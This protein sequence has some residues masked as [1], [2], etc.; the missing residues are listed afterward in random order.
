MQGPSRTS[1][2]SSIQGGTALPL[3]LSTLLAM[4][5]LVRGS[6]HPELNYDVIP[7]VA[8]AKHL[9]G[10]GGKA[11]AFREVAAK[12]GTERFQLY[13]AE[14]YRQRMYR[15]DEY[16]YRNESLYTI[17][18]FYILTCAAVGAVIHDDVAAT[19]LISAVSS[20]VAVLVSLLLAREVG[21]KGTWQL[22]APF[23]WVV[24][25]GL[26][27]AGLSTPDG[28]ETL[29]TLLFV[30]LLWHNAGSIVSY[31][32]L[33]MLAILMVATRTDAVVLV[34]FIL[35]VKWLYD[36]RARN[37]VLLLCAGSWLTYLF[38]QH[39]S[40]NFGYIAV[41]N[42]ALIE[43]GQHD[44]FPNLVPHPARFA[45]AFIH[46][47]LQVLGENPEF[48]RFFLVMGLLAFAWTRERQRA[49][50]VGDTFDT[51]GQ[52]LALAL[53][54][55]LFARFL[56]FPLP[57]SRYI[58]GAYVLPGLLFARA[59]QPVPSRSASAT[60]AASNVN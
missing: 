33:L 15:D 32:C 28:L 18:P 57:W 60:G 53:F 44:V 41:V 59:I 1:S 39:S 48:S 13:V 54:T 21:L 29:L 9:R 26:S 40:G 42:F 31:M 38:I 52:E 11:E 34:T 43:N 49:A 56:L 45:L 51:R 19:Y 25:G 12:V 17:R 20:A 7:Y 36:S 16:F 50:A 4:L 55:G 37:L 14:P 5:F 3:I 2:P 27:M 30:L 22:A 58:M 23:T 47:V 24:A 35:L 46:Q 10:T 8:L 6:L